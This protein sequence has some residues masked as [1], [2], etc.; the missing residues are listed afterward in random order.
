[1]RKVGIPYSFLPLLL[2]G[3]AACTVHYVRPPNQRQSGS[4]PCMQTARLSGTRIGRQITLQ[5][6]CRIQCLSSLPL[7]PFFLVDK[8]LLYKMNCHHFQALLVQ[9]SLKRLPYHRSL[10]LRLKCIV[11][12]TVRLSFKDSRI[13]EIPMICL[14]EVGSLQKAY[15]CYEGLQIRMAAWFIAVVRCFPIQ[16]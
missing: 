4:G 13:F 11:P 10:L 1:M 7:S 8:L 2:G 12:Q 5:S 3:R 16:G 15:G 9:P 14:L 6:T